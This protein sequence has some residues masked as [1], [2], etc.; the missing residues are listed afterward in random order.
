MIYALILLII[1]TFFY[2]VRPTYQ[3]QPHGLFLPDQP[4]Q[5]Y[6]AITPSQVNFLESLPPDSDFKSLGKISVFTHFDSTNPSEIDN[7]LISQKSFIQE[8]AAAHGAN[9]VVISMAG[10][11]PGDPNPLDAVMMNAM[12]LRI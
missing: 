10:R 1:G 6:P 2:A 11:S 4:T 5:E 8:L 7:I 9:T 12:A 3:Y